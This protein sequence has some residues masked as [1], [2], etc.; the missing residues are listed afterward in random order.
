MLTLCMIVRD[1]A[2][3]LAAC[4]GRVRSAVGQ[5]VVVDTGS[6][7]DTPAVARDLGAEVYCEPF[8]DFAQARNAALR[9][10]R[11]EWVLVLDADEEIDPAAL[12]RLVEEAERS[13]AAG[14]CLPRCDHVGRVGWGLSHPCRLF[15]HCPEVRYQHPVFEEP[16]F[17][18]PLAGRVRLTLAT[19][20]HHDGYRRP[21]PVLRER[22]VHY[23][24]LLERNR[25]EV[26][27]AWADCMLA[28]LAADGGDLNRALILLTRRAGTSCAQEVRSGE[29][30]ALLRARLLLAVGAPE[31]ALEVIDGALSPPDLTA[32]PRSRL[33][34]LRG[35]ALGRSGRPQEACVAFRRALEHGF[36]MAA[37]FF[38]LGLALLRVG[39]RSE[40]APALAA[41]VRLH[42]PLRAALARASGSRSSYQDH[43]VHRLDTDIAWQGHLN[44]LR[45]I[46]ES[47]SRTA[48][49][50]TAPFWEQYQGGAAGS[51]RPGPFRRERGRA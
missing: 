8:V 46:A 27:A 23:R 6:T 48:L 42:P 1:E 34:N 19:A 14:Y 31:R 4:V 47:A 25:D 24:T 32:Y 18:V 29:F 35:L 40:A 9:R 43:W 50:V 49:A 28:V 36:P 12:A 15:R 51:P 21:E 20:I 37:Y 45:S 3:R 11:G 44:D 30:V 39:R 13:G 10:V 5:V 26:D 16:V 38:N 41:A 7:D 17:P 22:R 2:R 33:E